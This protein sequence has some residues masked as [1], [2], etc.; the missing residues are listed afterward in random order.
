MLFL[1]VYQVFA[2][3]LRAPGG[4][5]KTV[6]EIQCV[7]VTILQRKRWLLQASNLA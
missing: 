4:D 7:F 1:Q 5:A 6:D 3:E 2:F